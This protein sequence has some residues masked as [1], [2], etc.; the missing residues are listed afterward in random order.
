[1]KKWL[2]LLLA[3]ALVLPFALCARAA[4]LR[5]NFY[6]VGKADA[7]LVTTPDGQRILIDA[8][9]NDAGKD[10]VKRFKAEEISSIDLMIITHF[11]KDHVG[12]AD[13]I[14]E[15]VAVAQVLI[16]QYDKDSKQYN[17]FLE[18][19]EQSPSTQVTRMNAGEMLEFTF[20][21]V[22]LNVTA[23]HQ[24][25]YGEDE[26]NDF[27]LAARMTYGDTR[28]LFAG[29]AEDARQREL[30]EE[31]NVACDVLKVPYHG[32]LVDASAAFLSAAHPQIAFITDSDDEP[33]SAVVIRLLEEQ[34]TAVYRASEGG[35]T[36][37]SDGKG[38]RVL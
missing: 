8:A 24:T 5:V 1:M 37:V 7:M 14:L 34:G 23:A 12:G 27:S 31:G 33:A 22:R 11:D 36:V 15:S 9:T 32:R 38:V 3:L 6:D 35:I 18:A 16:P 26:E 25:A 28:F 20:G 30:L 13:K 29:D 17:Q 21:D 2:P 19:L 4:E 10:L